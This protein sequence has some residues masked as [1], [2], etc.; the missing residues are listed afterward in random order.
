MVLWQFEGYLGSGGKTI[1]LKDNFLTTFKEKQQSEPLWEV[2]EIKERME[3]INKLIWS[4][5][6]SPKIS[7]VWIKR[8]KKIVSYLE[9]GFIK[10]RL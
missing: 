7:L 2:R 1:W 4:L 9:V 6:K 5:R 8:I 10:S 3:T